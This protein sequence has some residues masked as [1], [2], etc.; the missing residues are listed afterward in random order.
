M[1]RR[2]SRY[3]RRLG[4]SKGL[5]VYLKTRLPGTVNFTL[6]GLR[7]PLAMRTGTTD[8]TTFEQIFIDEQY[9]LSL[10]V[11]P[12]LIID[13]G[14]NIGYTAAIFAA[15]FPDA[16]VVAIEPEAENFAL[17]ERN[18]RVYPNVRRL[19]CAL[20]PRETRLIIENPEDDTNAFRVRE[21]PLAAEGIAAV[22]PAG[23]MAAANASEIDL[24]KLD[25]EGAEKE[26][27]EAADCG[28]WLLRTHVLMVELHERLRPGAQRAFE[29][30]M[31]RHAF[32]QIGA[33]GEILVM[34]RENRETPG[35]RS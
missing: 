33:V 34:E 6:A 19:K 7:A 20:W 9:D 3:A 5:E 10:V 21:D 14:A 27:F 18:T 30:A 29:Q 12:R 17:L 8:R 16:A 11:S 2:L 22:T 15:R 1:F 24:L 26:L 4:W 13:A 35:A 25:V 32:R 31:S 23:V 28:F